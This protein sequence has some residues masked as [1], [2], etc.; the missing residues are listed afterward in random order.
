MSVA[1]AATASGVAEQ[2][3]KKWFARFLL[4]GPAALS[5]SFKLAP[6][7]LLAIGAERAIA[8]VDLNRRG[9]RASQIAEMLSISL[10]QTRQVL[11]RVSGCDRGRPAPVASP[12]R[13]QWPLR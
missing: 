12:S 3:A 9:L 8:I 1:E 5:D 7:G 10:V 2:T 13:R 6:R 11:A 4:G